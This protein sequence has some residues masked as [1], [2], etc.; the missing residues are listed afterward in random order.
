MDMFYLIINKKT[1]FLSQKVGPGGGGASI[2][3]YYILFL[4]HEFFNR[5]SKLVG[6]HGAGEVFLLF[7]L[8]LFYDINILCSNYCNCLFFYMLNADVA[9][10]NKAIPRQ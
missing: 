1:N 6:C 9:V 7:D 2:Y 5:H 4:K 8:F 10:L 3:I